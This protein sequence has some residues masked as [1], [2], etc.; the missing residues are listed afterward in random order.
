MIPSR[1]SPLDVLLPRAVVSA[2]LRMLYDRCDNKF[3]RG[4]K[5]AGDHSEIVNCRPRIVVG[6]MTHV[7]GVSNVSCRKRSA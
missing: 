5:G 2:R 4:P 1:I 3:L 6:G 7:Q